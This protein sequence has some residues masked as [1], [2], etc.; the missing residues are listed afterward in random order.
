MIRSRPDPWAQRLIFAAIACERFAWYL[1]LAGLTL[2]LQAHG[3]TQAQASQLYGLL[4]FAAYMTPLVG[5][6]LAGLM[7]LRSAVAIGAAVL[8][9]AYFAGASGYLLGM[10]ALAAIGCGFFK[11]CLATLLG[12]LYPTND[13][14]KA[15]ALGTYYLC[16]NLGALPSALVGGWL[17]QHYGWAAAYSAAG[18]GALLALGMIAVAWRR[19]V[20][21]RTDLEALVQTEIA[22]PQPAE[23][24]KT[25]HLVTILVGGVLFWAANQQQGSTLTFWAAQRVD[26][27]TTWGLVPAESFASLNPLFVALLTPVVGRWAAHG[28]SRLVAAMLVVAGSFAVLLG[29]G[30]ASIGGLVLCYLLGALAEL[31]V[32]PLGMST[33]TDLVPRRFA[34]VAMSLWLLTTSAGGYLAGVFGGFKAETAAELTVGLACA[35]AVWFWVRWPRAEQRSRTGEQPALEAAQ[36]T[37]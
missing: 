9:V 28:R 6:Y 27:M 14:R 15:Q 30:G 22:A 23:T 21:F 11:P 24:W 29:P 8:A 7:P 31:L 13:P 33:V 2:A 36:V 32:S 34:A 5:G 18:L 20:P 35:G 3:K 17:R 12:L 1:V 4:L 19:L 16:I 37:A 25:G 26:R 10:L